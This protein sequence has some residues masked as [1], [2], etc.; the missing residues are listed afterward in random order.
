M[1]LQISLVDSNG[2]VAEIVKL[3][4]E[5][6]SSGLIKLNDVPIDLPPIGR[7]YIFLSYVPTDGKLTLSFRVKPLLGHRGFYAN[8][9]EFEVFIELKRLPATFHFRLSEH[10]LIKINLQTQNEAR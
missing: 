1:E 8:V 7:R 4:L 9:A 3:P 6:S 10:V 2:E 5:I